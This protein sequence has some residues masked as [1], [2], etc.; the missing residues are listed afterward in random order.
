MLNDAN[1]RIRKSTTTKGGRFQN[2]PL[3]HV[4]LEDQEN[5]GYESDGGMHALC[6]RL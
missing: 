4:S 5:E 2:Q 1:I 3:D 6:W